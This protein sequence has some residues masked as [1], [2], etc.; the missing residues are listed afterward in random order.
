VLAD[1]QNAR[2]LGEAM[3]RA[4]EDEPLRAALQ[5]KGF[6]RAKQF[7]WAQAATKTVALYRE[8]CGGTT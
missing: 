5:V 6:D 4:L 7:S 8:L 1:P 2:A 3:I